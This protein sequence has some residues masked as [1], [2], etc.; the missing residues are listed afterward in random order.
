LNNTNVI[1]NTFHFIQEGSRNERLGNGCLSPDW[2]CLE[3]VNHKDEPTSS[4]FTRFVR[5]G[6]N[7]LSMQFLGDGAG[8]FK[9]ADAAERMVIMSGPAS[10]AQSKSL[11]RDHRRKEPLGQANSTSPVLTT[12]HHSHHQ[13]YDSDIEDELKCDR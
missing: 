7:R 5:D 10:R 6:S 13:V 9:W 12:V 4:A 3:K 1:I 2:S 8:G 11:P